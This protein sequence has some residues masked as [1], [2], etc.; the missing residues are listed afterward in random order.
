[1]MELKVTIT[2]M[3]GQDIYT[4]I[5]L[6]PDDGYSYASFPL[7]MMSQVIRESIEDNFE[8]KDVS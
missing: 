2:K 1:M 5:V 7:D 4:F 8:T 3:S 6:A